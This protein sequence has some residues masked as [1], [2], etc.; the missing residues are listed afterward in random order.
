MPKVATT[1]AW[2]SPLVK[3]AEPCA[4][5]KIPVLISI[6]LTVR[7][8]LPSILGSPSKILF[9]TIEDS[10]LKSISNTEF[11]PIIASVSDP[12]SVPSA[13]IFVTVSL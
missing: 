1:R 9:L 10:S 11:S 8:S 2:V 13:N 12:V 5:G 3:S 6:G 4:L 7:V